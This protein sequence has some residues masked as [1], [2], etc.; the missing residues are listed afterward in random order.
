MARDL[1]CIMCPRGCNISIDDELNVTGN[2]CPKGVKYA[3]TEV[4]NPMRMVCTTV[5]TSFKDFPRLSV[6]TDDEIPLESIFEI[7]KE[8]NKIVVNERLKPGNIVKKNLCGTNVNLVA[9]SEM[10]EVV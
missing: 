9:T 2:Q 10:E 4:Q 6:K 3:R 8:I 7:M 5:Q 1:V